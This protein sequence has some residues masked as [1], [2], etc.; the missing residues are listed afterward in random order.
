MSVYR[1]IL[2][3]KAEKDIGIITKSASIAVRKKLAVIFDELQVHPTWGIGHPEEL[4]GDLAGFYSRQLDKKNRIIY[5]I[6]DDVVE[7]HVISLLG[8]YSDR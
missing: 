4:R 2:K 1:L 5:S 6:H 7:V 8:H 3:K